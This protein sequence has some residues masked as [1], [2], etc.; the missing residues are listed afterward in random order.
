MGDVDCHSDPSHIFVVG[1]FGRMLCWSQT[2]NQ[3]LCL[4]TLESTMRSL[5]ASVPSTIPA[6]ADALRRVGGESRNSVVVEARASHV[7]GRGPQSTFCVGW[8]ASTMCAQKGLK[9]VRVCLCP[10][11]AT[12]M[13]K[14]QKSVATRVWWKS[15]S[16]RSSLRAGTLASGGLPEASP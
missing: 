3:W 7:A 13:T 8:W 9:E 16:R 2:S 14:V 12:G 5:P 4:H 6:S 15:L 1:L 10:T 11:Q